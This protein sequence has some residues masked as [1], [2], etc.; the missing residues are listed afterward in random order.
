MLIC[1]KIMKTQSIKSLHWQLRVYSVAKRSEGYV[2]WTEINAITKNGKQ[3]VLVNSKLSA[4][5]NLTFVRSGN[6]NTAAVQV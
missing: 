1:M 3:I 2:T 4:D 5:G 6:T